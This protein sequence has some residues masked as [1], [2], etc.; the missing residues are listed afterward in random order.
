M[1]GVDSPVLTSLG[2][3]EE[4]LTLGGMA[5]VSKGSRELAKIVFDCH[6]IKTHFNVLHRSSRRPQSHPLRREGF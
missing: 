2:F 3:G 5:E 1:L 6:P 4:F